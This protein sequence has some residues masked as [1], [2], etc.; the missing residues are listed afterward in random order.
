[1]QKKE[2]RNLLKFLFE[3]GE[4][5]RVKRSGWWTAKV[6]NPESVAE[7]SFRCALIAFVLA[8]EENE[9][10][11]KLAV[12]SLFHDLPE[13]RILDLHKISTEY[14]DKKEAEKK[15][16]I[17]QFSLL[18][19]KSKKQV[20]RQQQKTSE[21]ERKILKDADLLE[22]AIQGREYFDAGCK[23]AWYWILAAER[24]T[25]TASARQLVSLLKKRNSNVWWEKLREKI[26]NGNG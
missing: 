10:A 24:K 5:K 22:C 16:A 12:L 14:I 2:A 21:K 7:H 4:L 6:Q 13:A 26:V 17:E 15:V 23:D 3:A 9:D 1:M 18:P 8:S 11:E 20:L 25:S 19:K